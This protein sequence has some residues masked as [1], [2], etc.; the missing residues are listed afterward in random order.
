VAGIT[1]A[2][3]RV[4]TGFEVSYRQEPEANN[5]DDELMSDVDQYGFLDAA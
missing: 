1:Q 2:R 3:H 4:S 5:D